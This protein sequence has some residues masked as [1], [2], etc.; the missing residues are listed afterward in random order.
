MTNDAKGR[1]AETPY[2]L[3]SSHW[4]T[5]LVRHEKGELQVKPYPGDPNPNSLIENLTNALDHPVR[6]DRP[7]VRRGWLEDGPGPDGRRGSHSL[8]RSEVLR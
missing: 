3:H 7:A 1:A 4:G 2:S 8:T 5:F 6:V